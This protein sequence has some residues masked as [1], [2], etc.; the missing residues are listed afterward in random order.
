MILVSEKTTNMKKQ[1]VESH[2]LLLCKIFSFHAIHI[3]IKVWEISAHKWGFYSLRWRL[4]TLF[5]ILL[6]YLPVSAWKLLML[7]TNMT[8][9]TALQKI[10]PFL[11]YIINSKW[12]WMNN[13]NLSVSLLLHVQESLHSWW[14]E[15]DWQESLISCPVMRFRVTSFSAQTCMS[16]Y[17]SDLIGSLKVVTH[18]YSYPKYTWL[19]MFSSNIRTNV[20]I[21]MYRLL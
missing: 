13:V 7:P 18:Y 17:L 15:D 4:F 14:S 12:W 6:S 16:I 5:C 21:K 9:S 1:N 20:K 3:F 10:S 11:I 8:L 19:W 2:I